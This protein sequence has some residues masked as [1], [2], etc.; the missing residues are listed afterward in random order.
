MKGFNPTSIQNFE[1][2]YLT[3]HANTV[4]LKD[5]EVVFFKIVMLYF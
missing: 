4:L 2:F 3:N 1:S 5:N